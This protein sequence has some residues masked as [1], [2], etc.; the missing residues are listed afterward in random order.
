MLSHYLTTAWRNFLRFKTSTLIGVVGLAL[1]L[2]CFIAAIGVLTYIESADRQLPNAD[3]I[4]MVWQRFGQSNVGLNT[5]FTAQTSGALAPA[6]RKEFPE[7]VAVAQ[8]YEWGPIQVGVRDRHAFLSLA[9]ADTDFLHVLNLPRTQSIAG[10]PLSQPRSVLLS[11]TAARRLFGTTAA[12]GKTLRLQN[13][14]DVTVTAVLKPLPQPS[15]IGGRYGAMSEPALLISRDTETAFYQASAGRTP[16]PAQW[17]VI[18]NSALYALLPPTGLSAA[19]LQSRLQ[20]IDERN[21]GASAMHNEFRVVP[22]SK[23]LLESLDANLLPNSRGITIAGMLM[24]LA[25]TVLIAAC[26]N[27]AHL[28]FSQS[29][30]HARET[31]LR[32]TIGARR[33]QLAAQA[34][35]EST[36]HV[37]FA[38]A[39]ALIIVAIVTRAVETRVQISASN[40]IVEST[41]FWAA[42]T[43]LALLV[44]I[45]IALYPALRLASVQPAQAVRGD[46]HRKNG[47]GGR[48]LLGAQFVTTSALIVIVSV[49][50][51]QNTHARETALSPSK[52]PVIA[53]GSSWSFG[54]TP[55]D[56][57]RNEL[58]RS[59][60]I[61]SISATSN[62]PWTNSFP[63]TFPLA[64]S[65]GHRV[66]N[67]VVSDVA[68]GFEKTL[69][70]TVIAGR[71]FDSQFGD[72]E[73]SITNQPTI[74]I[75]ET[76]VHQLG[77]SKPSDAIGKS[78]QRT[79]PDAKTP[80]FTII[81]V[82]ADKPLRLRPFLDFVGNAYVASQSAPYLSPILTID[83]H[84]ITE[85]L[86]AIDAT[87]KKFNPNEPVDRQF[88]DESFERAYA[89]YSLVG[90]VLTGIAS[91]ALVIA[92]LGAFGFSSFAGRLRAHEI[93]VR[94][95][96]GA[97]TEQIVAMLLRDF[98]KPVL[99]ANI[100]A[101]PLAYFAVQQYL[102]MFVQRIDLTWL[103]FILS[104]LLTL[105]IAWAA[106]GRQAYRA[107]KASP[108]SALRRE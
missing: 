54:G 8:I 76:L 53:L 37:S 67:A 75:D 35:V 15:H 34:F 91:I 82:V 40:A 107:A 3:R 50:H 83:R 92:L 103:P 101:W 108:S 24:L 14:L 71:S 27:Y 89:F 36:C 73:K 90:N 23:A 29:S 5:T 33:S 13:A 97:R 100:V 104:S 79:G 51:L 11:E 74:V 99:L 18:L 95:T 44:S 87:W 4:V 31:G 84:R 25:F 6:M 102:D 72:V 43:F 94:K 22:L 59:P 105:V 20:G 12:L 45:G 32:R 39:A 62:P 41:Q 80:P 47:S 28:A 57:W 2:A 106:V 86:S 77:F 88:A 42:A 19:S 30:T 26:V 55:F 85:G 10:N 16:G 21:G 46:A 49:V 96:L 93:G 65:F 58:L 78:V 66:F 61:R 70:L 7:L 52:D 48:I 81:G 63:G 56:T 1:G 38:S 9:I 64:A 17:G 98:S 68:Y 69:D 60:A